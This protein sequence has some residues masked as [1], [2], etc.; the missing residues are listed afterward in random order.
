M[1]SEGGVEYV[2]TYLTVFIN[3]FLFFL[4]FT[5]KYV[6]STKKCHKQLI[7]N[8]IF[9]VYTVQHGTGYQTFPNFSCYRTVKGTFDTVT[10]L[11]GR[12]PRLAR[13]VILN[14]YPTAER[15]EKLNVLVLTNKY[16]NPGNGV[17]GKMLVIAALHS[18][19]M[20]PAETGECC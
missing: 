18:Q 2:L 8:L 14:N 4:M 6:C 15:K 11:L 9:G 16:F 17:K 13:R 12:Y 1:L 19:E 5:L 10:D 3:T 7:N 20:T